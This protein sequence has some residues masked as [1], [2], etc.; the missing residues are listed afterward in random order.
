M[1][2]SMSDLFQ[3]LSEAFRPDSS[4][5]IRDIN[6]S[7]GKYGFIVTCEIENSGKPRKVYHVNKA[8]LHDWL[9]EERPEWLEWTIDKPHPV[10]GEHVQQVGVITAEEYATEHMC[11]QEWHEYLIA[12]GLTTYPYDPE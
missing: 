6:A 2:A 7:E 12:N 11:D 1:A 5:V 9:E 3:T 10:T 4:P 8:D